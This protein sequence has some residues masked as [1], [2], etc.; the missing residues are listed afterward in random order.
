[1]PWLLHQPIAVVTIRRGIEPIFVTDHKKSSVKKEANFPPT[2]F[3]IL[4]FFVFFH[5]NHDFSWLFDG[6]IPKK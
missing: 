4:L 3:C 6:N 1:M 5:I 2:G